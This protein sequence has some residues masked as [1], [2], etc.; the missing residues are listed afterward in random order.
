MCGTVVEGVQTALKKEKN[1]PVLKFSG[2]AKSLNL[3]L[4]VV[5]INLD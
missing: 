4:H 2:F 5:L 3:L 1:N